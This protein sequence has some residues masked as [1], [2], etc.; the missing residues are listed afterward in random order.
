MFAASL[1]GVLSSPP[2]PAFYSDFPPLSL[3]LSFFPPL[4]IQSLAVGPAESVGVSR[5]TMMVPGSEESIGKL[6]R[7]LYK[8][9][10]VIQVRTL[11][12]S[13]NPNIRISPLLKP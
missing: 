9:I 6:L 3:S 2:P 11:L 8:L 10:D 13:L 4:R 5:I 7:Q 12:P 1:P